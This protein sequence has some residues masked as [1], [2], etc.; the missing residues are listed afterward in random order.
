MTYQGST[1]DTRPIGREL[2]VR[3]LVIG[4]MARVGELVRTNVQLVDAASG[5]QFW[6]DRFEYDFVD[7]GGLENAI[8][9]RI[10]ASLNVQ[11]VRVEG[12]RAEKA[13]RPDA[14]DLRLRATSLFFGSVAPEHTLAVRALLQQSVRLDPSP[15]Q[16]SPP[17]APGIL[18]Y[19]LHQ[20]NNTP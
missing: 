1:L 7:L 15:A 19:H 13:V 8:T 20:S 3:Y 10:A 6:G 12:R 17:L 14:L 16:P 2:G 9:G 5:E 4:S 18:P 11:L